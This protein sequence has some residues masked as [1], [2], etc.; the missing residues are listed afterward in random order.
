MVG[1]AISPMAITVAPTMP[2]EAANSAPT[3]ITE[4][5][6]APEPAAEL[7]HGLEKRLRDAALLKDDPHQH[8][9]RNRDQHVIG[10]QAEDALSEAAE[11]RKV[12]G[13]GGGS[14]KRE[15]RCD[16]ATLKAAGKMSKMQPIR[17]ANI[18]R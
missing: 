10:Q 14:E 3:R 15:R 16:P 17:A 4:T 5:P 12:H 1:C 13:A 6:S 2:V 7:T 8:E 18:S 11:E 9:R